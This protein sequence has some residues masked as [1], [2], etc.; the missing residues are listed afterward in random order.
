MTF[1][2]AGRGGPAPASATRIRPVPGQKSL[3]YRILALD[4]A[5]FATT[6]EGLT[7]IRMIRVAQRRD[8]RPAFARDAQGGKGVGWSR[9]G[10]TGPARWPQPEDDRP[11][12]KGVARESRSATKGRSRKDSFLVRGSL[13]SGFRHGQANGGAQTQG[14]QAGEVRLEITGLKVSGLRTGR[15][16]LETRKQAPF[17]QADCAHRGRPG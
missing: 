9:S 3:G 11:S 5:F 15:C 16:G 2:I 8:T 17:C 12:G 13:F 10:P 7:L 6:N 4:T 1:T 14:R